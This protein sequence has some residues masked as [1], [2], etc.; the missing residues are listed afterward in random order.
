MTSHALSG[1]LGR[2]LSIDLC[3]GCQAFWFDA[4]ES[5]QLTPASTLKLFQLIGDHLADG[6]PR[7]SSL[8]RAACPRC[9]GALRVTRDMQ[10]NTRFEYL[11]CPAGHGRLTTFFNFLREKNFVRPL[12]PD[13]LAELRKN[14][15]AVNCSNCG[16]PID[17]AARTTCG[18]CGSALSML[19]MT[20]ASRLIEALRAA[21]RAG[22]PIDPTLPLQLEQTRRQMTLMFEGIERDPSWLQTAASVGLVGAG[23]GAVARWLRGRL[24]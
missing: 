5:L 4:R 2:P 8:T 22:A 15:H 21:D 23:L 9:G 13:Q 11:N 3:L 16:A 7:S 17:L 6:R 19:D 10:R 18:H 12:S 24:D 20:Q 1:H 14:V